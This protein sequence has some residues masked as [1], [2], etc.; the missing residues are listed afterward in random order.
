MLP[1]EALH[2]LLIQ[3]GVS[4]TARVHD[5]YDLAD[6]LLRPDSLRK[7]LPTLPRHLLRELTA[8]V[9]TTDPTLHELGLVG[10]ENNAAIT[11][12]RVSAAIAELVDSTTLEQ[13][14][15][16]PVLGAAPAASPAR[17]VAVFTELHFALGHNPARELGRGGFGL[18]EQRRIGAEIDVP[19]EFVA[20]IISL[21]DRAG[22]LA[23]DPAGW[24]PTEAGEAWSHTSAIE[25]WLVLAEAWRHSIPAA[26]ARLIRDYPDRSL[27][28]LGDWAF[29][30]TPDTPLHVRILAH[31]AE[32]IGVLNHPALLDEDASGA[33]TELGRALLN[34]EDVSAAASALFPAPV[35]GIYLQ[36]D[37]SIIAPGM[38]AAETETALRGFADLETR[39]E[40]STYRLTEASIFRGLT[41]GS[42]VKE[43]R[44]FL[45]DLSLTGVPQPISYLVER[46][47]ERFGSITVGAL[48]SPVPGSPS[49]SIITTR[50]PE[51]LDEILVDRT[52]HTLGL[53]RRS[54]TTAVST[55]DARILY[56][57]LVDAK[58]PALAVDEHGAPQHLRRRRLATVAAIADTGN[59]TA[60]IETL[61]SADSSSADHGDD[62]WLLR[63]LGVAMR[64]RETLIVT[65]AIPDRGDVDFILEPTGVGGGR[66]RG[67]DKA[68]ETE[69]TLPLARITRVALA[70]AG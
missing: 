10:R 44:S 47:A 1:A 45:A 49:V 51:L 11:L 54:P 3:R 21:G 67:I 68:A 24:I 17:G 32:V 14:A 6:L 27:L 2:A 7:I 31:Q 25:R 36:H 46:A 35:Q 16:A 43:I 29:P 52:L 5:Y 19:S 65:V 50:T 57:G 9:P 26:L 56:W 20:A 48:E 28:E 55:Y 34:G 42:T 41:A 53:I 30:A 22:L 63:R 58:Y 13:A 40:A 66:L 60:L 62:A 15:P 70:P 33:V 61:R 39:A 4:P 64:L 59:Y 23:R 69:R 38:L 8:E 18:P 37:L 12:H